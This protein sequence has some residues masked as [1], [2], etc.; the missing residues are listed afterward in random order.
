MTVHVGEWCSLIAPTCVRV[1]VPYPGIHR[2][3][4]YLGG[5]ADH[6]SQPSRSTF[7]Q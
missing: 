1:P 6:I 5:R 4:L 7:R 3:S 2:T